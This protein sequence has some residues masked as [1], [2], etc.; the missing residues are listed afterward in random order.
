[1]VEANILNHPAVKKHLEQFDPI[2]YA[3]M[4]V[5]ALIANNGDPHTNDAKYG[6]KWQFLPCSPNPLELAAVQ[7]ASGKAQAFVNRPGMQ[8]GDTE[9]L[10][11]V[12][13]SVDAD[14]EA[15]PAPARFT[16]MPKSQSL[17][18]ELANRPICSSLIFGRGPVGAPWATSFYEPGTGSMIF[19]CS[20]MEAATAIASEIVGV[21]RRFIGEE[22]Q[23]TIEARR[24][25]FL[26]SRINPF[27]VGPDATEDY[28]A[29][30]ALGPG[31]DVEPGK[32]FK[33]QFDAFV[34][35][36]RSPTGPRVRSMDEMFDEFLR[37]TQQYASDFPAPGGTFRNT[38]GE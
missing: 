11:F 36:V 14:D 15:D 9:F 2:D 22:G 20:N 29:A 33:R 35:S 27:F 21:G 13:R 18:L 26:T 32:E 5:P 37:R 16:V 23:R 6:V 10:G 19:Q 24:A 34:A 30:F 12:A 4:D 28:D 8:G 31:Q 3:A 1:V 25:K 7:G 38:R 17:N